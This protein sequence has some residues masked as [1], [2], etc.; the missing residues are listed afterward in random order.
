MTRQN[1]CPTTVRA[2]RLGLRR[3]D[4]LRRMDSGC[5]T[6]AR[7]SMNGAVIGIWLIITRR[8]LSAI[9]VV[10]KAASE[11]LLAEGLGAITLKSRVVPRGPVFRRR[12]SMPITDFELLVT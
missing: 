3:L 2:G 1:R 4:R 7:M 10:R 8:Q 5:T 6:F 11:K 9:L 12:S